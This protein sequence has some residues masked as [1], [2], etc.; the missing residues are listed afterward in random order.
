MTTFLPKELAE[1][2]QMAQKQRARAASRLR[3]EADGK[4]YP[5]LKRWE[6]GFS[7]DT[8]VVPA[9]RGH[10][11]LFEGSRFLSTCLII[12]SAEEPGVM[13]YEF[14]WATPARDKPP[15]DFQQAPDA[16]VA[17]LGRPD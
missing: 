9:L 5:V 13:R 12:A 16:P 10:V 2:L 15:V 3:V 1:G 4:S 8:D 14:K 17:L 6:N 11:D 7:V